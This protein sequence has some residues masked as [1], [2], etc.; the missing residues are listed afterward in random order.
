MR[1]G[2]PIFRATGL[3]SRPGGTIRAKGPPMPR[4]VLPFD[5]LA[6]GLQTKKADQGEGFIAGLGAAFGNVDQG[7]DVCMP[8]CFAKSLVEHRANGTMPHMFWNHGPS[9]VGDWLNMEEKPKGLLCE[10]NIWTGKGIQDAE[11]ARMVAKSK[12]KRGLSIGYVVKQATIDQAT[13]I[14]RLVELA[15]EEVS[16]VLFPMNQSAIIEQAKGLAGELPSIRDL[17]TVLRDAGLSNKQAKA[18]LARGFSGLRDA[19]NSETE[20]I[21]RMIKGLKDS[22][23]N[24]IA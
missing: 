5:F 6:D 18:L 19:D 10:G 4:I 14:R 9:P 1:G 8:G 2:G 7:G 21:A 22:I 3:H 15:L 11:R 24:S 13:G 20:E 23:Q 17:E 16:I 12:T